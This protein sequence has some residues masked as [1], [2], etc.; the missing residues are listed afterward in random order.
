MK[1]FLNWKKGLLKSTYEIYSHGTCI[2]SL[3]EHTLT[4]CAD[5]KL[6]GKH[7]SFNT[8]GFLKQETQIIDSDNFSPV[9]KI[10]YNSWM[11]RATITYWDKTIFWKYNNAWNTKWCLYDFIEG[12]KINYYGSSTRGTIESDDENELLLLTGLYITNYY[13]QTSVAVLIACFV[14]IWVVFMN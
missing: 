8:K 7:Y 5:G 6:N 12:V 10:T 1:T 2:G 9:G 4:Q 13:W 14:P 3:R 11:T